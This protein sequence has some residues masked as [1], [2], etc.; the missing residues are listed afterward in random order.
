MVE[1]RNLVAISHS[2][3][4]AEVIDIIAMHYGRC[5]LVTG[6][7]DSPLERLVDHVLYYGPVVDRHSAPM[8]SVIVAQIVLDTAIIMACDGDS[9]ALDRTHPGGMIGLHRRMTR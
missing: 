1:N 5:Y 6:N 3:G 9:R 8:E 7:D 4:T 2:G